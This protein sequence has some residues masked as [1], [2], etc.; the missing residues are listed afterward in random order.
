MKL[1][2]L[3]TTQ[4]ACKTRTNLT[5]NNNARATRTII[6]SIHRQSPPT[7]HLTRASLRMIMTRTINKLLK[8]EIV[9]IGGCKT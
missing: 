7:K 1:I 9:L 4:S 5:L 3:S 8:M 6:R 2:K